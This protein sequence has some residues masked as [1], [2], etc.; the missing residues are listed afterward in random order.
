M[1][2]RMFSA[3]LTAS[4]A[5]GIPAAMSAQQPPTATEVGASFVALVTVPAKSA[6]KLTVTSPAFAAGA[7]IPFE[8]TQYRGNV[9]PGLAWTAGPAGTKSYAV[10]MQDG[11]GV[12]NNAPYL[13]WTM[14]NVPASVTKLAVGMTTQPAGAIYGPNYKGA[15]QPYLGP[16]TPAGPKHRYHI[17]IFALDVVLPADAAASYEGITSAMK[18]HV[19]ASGELVGLGQIAPSTPPN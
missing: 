18:D 14:I 2:M 8:N 3:A 17:Q 9:F 10:I 5:G 6:S 19:L 7:D 13:H 12:R 4:L 15:N 16:R 11:D 1:K